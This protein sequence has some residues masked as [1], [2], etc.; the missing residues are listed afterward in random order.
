MS[1]MTLLRF[2]V[3]ASLLFCLPSG[4][5]AETAPSKQS[6]TPVDRLSEGWWAARHQ[7]VLEAVKAHP[8]TQLLLIGDSITNNY[9]KANLPDENFQ[10]TWQT[11]YEPRH[12]LNLGFSG[13]ATEHV[14][15]RLAHGEADG[16]HPKAIVLLIGTNNTGHEGQTALETEVGIDAVVGALEVRM[17]EAKILLLGLLPSDISVEKTAK[18]REVNRYLANNYGVNARVAYLDVSSVLYRGGVLDTA[19][20]YDPRLPQHGKAL[21]PDTNGQRMMAEA[22]EPTLAKLMDEAPRVALASMTEI[23]TALIPVPRLEQD[24]YDWFARHAAELEVQR[25]A[26]PDVVL[27]GDSIT[28]FW[29]GAPYGGRRSGTEAWQRVFGGMSAI[30]MGFGWDRTQNVLWRLEHGEFEGLPPKWVVLNIGTNNLTGTGNARA[31]TPEEVV[32]GIA[33]ICSVVHQRSPGTKIL[34]M[35]VFPRGPKADSPL[36]GPIAAVNKLLEARFVGDS[37]V[38]LLDIGGKFLDA[39]GSLPKGMMP[40]GTHPSEAGYAIW[41]DALIAAGVRR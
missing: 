35:K 17:P 38:T 2:F 41:A 30:N 37:V 25:G 13:D 16:L 22:M 20:Y 1:R 7:S 29:D 39:D 10:P 32:E 40:D 23:D 8:E 31:S 5:L 4:L 19:L 15:W 27:I 33:A 12:A 3:F 18:D 9:D 11:F 21:H 24:S 36:R 28:H 6:V 14:L 26:K 34:V